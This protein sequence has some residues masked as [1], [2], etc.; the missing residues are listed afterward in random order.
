[1]KTLFSVTFAAAALASATTAFPNAENVR[2]DGISIEFNEPQSY[3]DFKITPSNSESQRDYLIG[4]MRDEINTA[5][6]RF[7]P[8]GYQLSL[9][10]NDID[11][12]GE[13]LP[14]LGPDAD[15]VR[16]MRDI[17]P[18]RVKIEYALAD[19]SGNVLA[20]GEK[21]LSDLSYNFKIRRPNE[22]EVSRESELVVELVRKISRDAKV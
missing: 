16:I 21:T 6:S 12:A 13:F 22:S 1:M 20:S 15:Q 5:V 2:D 10:I 11:M 17:D 18:P 4:K 19:A 8:P 3:T 9:R 14:E 7:L